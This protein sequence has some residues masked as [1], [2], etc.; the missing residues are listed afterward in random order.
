MNKKTSIIVIAALVLPVGCAKFGSCG[1]RTVTVN[2]NANRIEAH[3][4]HVRN[5]CRG[6]TLTVKLVPPV[7]PG[8]AHTAPGP[9]DS[10]ATWLS[11]S[12]TEDHIL[13]VVDEE[14]E[15]DRTYKYSITI[16]G[17]TLDPR[18]TVAK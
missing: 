17:N 11:G 12:N 3:P 1:D 9:E 16:D 14:A 7:G 13:L 4:E 6:D 8:S 18:V 2:H 5:I 15:T 10:D